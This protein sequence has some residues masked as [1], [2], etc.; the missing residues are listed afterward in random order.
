MTISIQSFVP[1]LAITALVIALTHFMSCSA[2]QEETTDSGPWEIGGRFREKWSIPTPTAT[3]D[4]EQ[5]IISLY[6]NTKSDVGN[7]NGSEENDTFPTDDNSIRVSS[8]TLWSEECPSGGGVELKVGNHRGNDKTSSFR[9]LDNGFLGIFLENG[10]VDVA[11][12]PE[13]WIGQSSDSDPA[14]HDSDPTTVTTTQTIRFCVRYAVSAQHSTDPAV[15][16]ALEMNFVETVVTAKATIQNRRRHLRDLQQDG[17]DSDFSLE[18]ITISKKDNSVYNKLYRVEAFM[19]PGGGNNRHIQRPL[20]QGSF[21]TICVQPDEAAKQDGVLVQ[22]IRDFTFVLMQNMQRNLQEETEPIGQTL[23]S[24][25]ERNR[26]ISRGIGLNTDRPAKETGE[27]AFALTIPVVQT[28]QTA[29][30]DGVVAN[31]LTVYEGCFG[32]ADLSINHCSFGSILMSDFYKSAAKVSGVGV[33][34]LGYA[35]LDN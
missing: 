10:V 34:T 19:C 4:R 30:Q 24:L 17:D 2:A 35:P 21:V 29:M 20:S 18:D 9:N 22:S 1:F 8:A 23:G 3:L 16:P 11:L 5:N 28:F 31:P 25:K 33:V 7:I 13:Y 27:G 15:S 14:T 12:K 32:V 26:L 6:Y